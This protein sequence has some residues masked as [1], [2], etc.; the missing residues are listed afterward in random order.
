MV[1][2]YM[3][4]CGFPV[5]AKPE[6]QPYLP[7]QGEILFQDDFSD[8]NSGWDV[9]SGEGEMFGPGSIGYKDGVYFIISNPHGLPEYG[10]S[11]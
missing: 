9:R 3:I 7:Q 1:L 4:S 10:G 2:L 8:P 6:I 5:Q 11:N